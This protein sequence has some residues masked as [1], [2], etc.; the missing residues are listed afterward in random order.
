MAAG[1]F[2]SIP[3]QVAVRYRKGHERKV[4]DAL[5]VL[6]TLEDQRPRR[7]L[8]LHRGQGISSREVDALLAWL[9]DRGAIEFASAVLRDIESGTRQ[10]LT[11]E[12][13]VRLKQDAPARQT[14]E[15]LKSQYGL[16]A[17]KRNAY[18]PTQYIVKVSDPSGTNTLDVAQSLCRCKEVE[19]ASPNFLTE[20][21]AVAAR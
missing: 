20:V 9:R 19:F 1:K 13:V 16:T 10:V 15:T 8:I 14:L 21:T 3:T 4:A 11:D 7:I 6:G 18:E 17:C 12:I 5:S 2:R